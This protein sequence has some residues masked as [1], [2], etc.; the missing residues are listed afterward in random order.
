VSHGCTA[1]G[2]RNAGG[3]SEQLC[4]AVERVPRKILHW[5]ILRRAARLSESRCVAIR[6]FF[7]F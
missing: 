1:H 7:F 3:V 2:L 4:F 5:H 6:F